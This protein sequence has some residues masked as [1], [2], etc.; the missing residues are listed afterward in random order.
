MEGTG[1]LLSARFLTMQGNEMTVELA[2]PQTAEYHIEVEAQIPP[3]VYD[4]QLAIDFHLSPAAGELQEPSRGV[5]FTEETLRWL[6]QYLEKQNENP[7]ESTENESEHQ[8]GVPSP[9]SIPEIRSSRNPNHVRNNL[10]SSP[11]SKNK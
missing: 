2:I 8:Q 11:T 9:P 3:G 4:G 7:P 1:N 5:K 6:Q 10:Q